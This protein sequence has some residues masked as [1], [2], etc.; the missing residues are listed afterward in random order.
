VL[1]LDKHMSSMTSQIQCGKQQQQQQGLPWL[2][3]MKHQ[4]K[5]SA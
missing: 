2:C 1:L 4:V 3:T 5:G